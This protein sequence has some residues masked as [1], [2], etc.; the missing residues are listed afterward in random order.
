MR[1]DNQLLAGA[2]HPHDFMACLPAPV[3]VLAGE[4][5]IEDD[6]LVSQVGILLQT[7]QEER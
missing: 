6:D 4:G 7:G 1:K 2:R 3:H 5:I